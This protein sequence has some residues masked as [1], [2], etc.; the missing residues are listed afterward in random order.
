MPLIVDGHRLPELPGSSPHEVK[1]K[2]GARRAEP[3]AFERV[4]RGLGAAIDGGERVMARAANGAYEQMDAKTL[5]LLQ[6]GIYRYGEAIDLTAK[7]VDRIAGAA[8][9]ILEAG[10]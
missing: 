3:S 8:K 10:R 9:T 1:A 4:A 5:I 7:L 6:G 2:A